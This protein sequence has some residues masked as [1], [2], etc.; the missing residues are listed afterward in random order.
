MSDKRELR[1]LLKRLII[2]NGMIGQFVM[3]VATDALSIDEAESL[4]EEVDAEVRE[5]HESG[6]DGWMD[7]DLSAQ[8]SHKLH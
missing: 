6:G 5:A 2:A 8:R 7:L 4:W 3:D 1:D